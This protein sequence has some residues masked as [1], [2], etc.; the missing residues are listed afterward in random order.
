MEQETDPKHLLRGL[1]AEQRLAVSTDAGP[2]VI[3]AG[4]GSGKTTVLTRRIAHRIAIDT[5]DARHVLALTFTRDAAGE[6]RRRLRR[7]DTRE[8]IESGTF[9]AVSLRLLRDRALTIGTTP[10]VL[11]PDRA[12]LIREVLTETRVRCEVGAAIAD[13]DWARARLVGPREYTDA[14]RRA[15]RR[16]ALNADAFEAVMNR[17]EQIKRR[18]RVVDFDDLLQGVLDQMASD[19]TF[20]DIVRWRFRHLFVDEAQDLNPLQFALLEHIRGGRPDVCLVGDHRQAVYGWNGADPSMLLE[21][22]QRFPGVTIVHLVGNYRC[23]PQIVAGAAAALVPADIIDDGISRRPDG[24]PPSFIDCLDEHDE[25]AQVTQLVRG[26]SHRHG[27]D[28]VAVLARTND[29]LVVLSR[30]MN[31]AGIPTRRAVGASP[32]ERA[33]SE[34]ARCTNRERLAAWAEAVWDAESVDPMRSRVAE[35]VD[36]FLTSGEQGSFRGWVEARQPFDDL[37]VDN[38]SGAVAVLTFHAAKGREWPA[39]VVTGVEVGLVPHGSASGLAQRA[40]EAR[41]LYV[42]LTR[43]S[44]DLVVTA[45]RTRNGST[46]G[47]SP[48]LQAVHDACPAEVFSG[49]PPPPDGRPRQPRLTD[50]MDE[51]RN[52]RTTVARAGSV[53]DVAVCPDRILRALLTQRPTNVAELAVRLGMTVTATERLAPQLF[54]IL[55]RLDAASTMRTPPA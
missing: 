40:E 12:R 9:H 30:A 50:P 25:A 23:S 37:E 28:H 35:E 44:D 48:W 53:D 31:K 47:P 14:N 1:D 7:L 29:Q 13:I 17:Y 27:Y 10:P 49:P 15:R 42:A 51:L 52:W 55:D 11:A 3:V 24:R 5:A 34:A 32:L 8:P 4:A 43:A 6:L 22:E 33:I 45:A 41:L 19:P 39:V 46:T 2:L 16:N 26:L 38:E 18:R 21:A 36:R 20:T 54:S